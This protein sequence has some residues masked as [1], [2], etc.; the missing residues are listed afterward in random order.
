[1]EYTITQISQ[2]V[3]NTERVN[4]FLNGR[5][6]IGLNKN[7]LVTL[8]LYKGQQ[9]TETEKKDVE[10]RAFDSNLIGRVINYI[11]LRPRSCAEVR[12]YLVYRK[13]VPEEDADN[14]IAY[15]QEQGLLSDEKFA[16]WYM[17]Y[18]ISSGV[19]GVNK[20]KTELMQ[21]RVDRKV[22]D[23]I[24]EK[25]NANEEFKQEQTVKI[26]EYARKLLPT[27]KA[28]DT[29][30]RK[31]KLTSRLMARGFKYNDIKIVVK[32]LLNA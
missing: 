7:D 21:K 29:Y 28:K 6:W 22:I 4:L 31:S 32:T 30:E 11:Q 10:A 13:K 15:L 8:K 12:D 18:K 19:N 25:M 9:I 24:L 27:I 20:I 16:Q 26:E 17:D 1:M 3:K 2:A 23:S 5:F 14:V